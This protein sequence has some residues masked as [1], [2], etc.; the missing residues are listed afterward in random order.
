[1]VR[2]KPWDKY[3]AAVLL[4]AYIKV[5]EDGQNRKHIISEVSKKLRKR[6]ENQGEIIDDVF[7]NNAGITFQMQSMESAYLGYTVAKPA[8]KLF[9]DIVKLRRDNK[10]EYDKILQE[11]NELVDIPL[12]ENDNYSLNNA[13]SRKIQFHNWMIA[14]GMA[15]ATTRVYVSSMTICGKLAYDNGII[16]KDI[17]QIDDLNTLK[18]VLTALL[19][20]EEFLEKNETRHNQFRAAFTKYV[21]FSGDM[22]FTAPV[23]FGG[24]SAKAV[25]LNR[26]DEEVKREYPELYMRLKSMSKVYDDLYGF[27][28][29]YIGDMLGMTVEQTILRTV[30]DK[31]SWITQVDEDVYSFSKYAKPYEKPIEFDKEAFIRVLMSRYPNGMRFDSI[32]F[33]NFRDTYTDLYND[34]IILSDEDLEIC[35]RKCGVFYKER[36][37]PAEGVINGAVKEKLLSYIENSF[38]E[39]KTVLYYKAIVTDLSDEFAYCYNLMEPMMLKPYLEYVCKGE[40]YF[41][42]DEFLSKD[43]CVRVDHSAEIENFLLA[44]G[45]PVSYEEIYSG[46]SHIA[47]D[48]V[49]HE[50]KTNENIILNGREHYFHY[51]IFEFSSE[52]ADKITDFI[53]NEI[54]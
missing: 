23:V 10:D 27:S 54:E 4:E 47:Q 6:A 29:E 31:V 12:E 20:N 15:E 16:D 2:Q 33:D 5:S 35:L 43:K 19:N 30:L 34:N 37:F 38:A 14:G 53:N 36:L 41:Y 25:K 28:L 11:A 24:T 13:K 52:D 45:K 26:C 9:S 1:M 3:E 32:D 39:G 44:V 51:G 17:F 22:S 18:D 42:Y 49:Y 46:L 50:I 21:Q 7:R 8:T 48:I 40:N